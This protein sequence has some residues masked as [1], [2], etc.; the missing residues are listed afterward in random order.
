MRVSRRLLPLGS[1]FA[2]ACHA[3]PLPV[4]APDRD[5][6]VVDAAM[7]GGDGTVVDGVPRYRTLGAAL[8]AAPTDA[9]SPWRIR[10]A[11]GRYRE[12]LSIDKPFIS[13][14]G[15]GR[16]RTIITYDAA[17]DTKDPQGRAYGTRGSFTIRVTAPDFHAEHLTI[18]NAFD[19]DANARKPASDATKLRNTQGVALA[20]TDGSD[21][22]SF[23]DVALLGHQDT[24]FAN[25]GRQ[26]FH[27]CV[28]AGHVDFIFGAGQAAFDDCRIISLDRGSA[29]EN[30]F[31]TAPSTDIA[32][33]YGFLFVNSRLEK[34]RPG[35]AAGSV[36][37]GRNWHPSA[38]PRANGEA[39]FV[40]CWMDD[41]ISARG[42][43]R[44]SSVDSATGVRYWFEPGSAR[45]LE[46]HSTGPGAI[47]SP[48]RRVL[49]DGD[50]RS[51]SV[52]RVLGDW[53]PGGSR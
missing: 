50:A 44:M 18:E 37:L 15:E 3:G 25:A 48:T 8:G 22:A 46:Y 32:A 30:G 4:P 23:E 26:Y 40:D 2:L 5:A 19:Y 36:A 49:S 52:A 34:E 43:D 35:M 27:H 53:T 31:L 13:F 14:V 33:P 11:A 51:Y 39:V 16:E 21:R 20:T 47:S 6:A 10:I 45:F 9:R 41:H 1:L 38:T 42:W 7:T 12:K 24:Y 28:V 29:T 17:S